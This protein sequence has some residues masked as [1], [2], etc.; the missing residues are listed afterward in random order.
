MHAVKFP[1]P[2]QIF[3]KRKEGWLVGTKDKLIARFK[4][5][6]LTGTV[7]VNNSG[8]TKKDEKTLVVRGLSNEKLSICKH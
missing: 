4:E 3:F 7:S 5:E 2:A 6:L 1:L 8:K